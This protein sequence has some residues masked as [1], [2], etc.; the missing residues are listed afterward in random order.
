MENCFEC[1]ELAT[2]DHH[3]IPQVMG[4]MKTVPLCSSC[5]MK[6]HGISSSR[7]TDNHLENTKRGLDKNRAWELFAVHQAYMFYEAESGKEVQRIFQEV[8]DHKISYSKALR[9]SKRYF[10]IEENYLQI[11]FN[12][13]IDSDLSYTWNPRDRKLRDEII[14]ETICEMNSKHKNPNNLS[15]SEI[16][17]IIKIAEL[18]YQKKIKEIKPAATTV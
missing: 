1:G 6:V 13:K 4:G 16:Q 17:E 14:N 2:E 15:E 10:E 3:V 11:L 8:F 7:R 5:H 9:L 18:N 12:N